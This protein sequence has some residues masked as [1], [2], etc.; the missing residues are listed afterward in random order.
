M[1]IYINYATSPSAQGFQFAKDFQSI[2]EQIV[3]LIKQEYPEWDL[4]F[5]YVPP[6]LADDDDSSQPGSGDRSAAEGET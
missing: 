5:L 4:S 2:G 6:L 3:D 1:Y